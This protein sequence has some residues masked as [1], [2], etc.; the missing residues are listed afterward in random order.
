MIS[1]VIQLRKKEADAESWGSDF[2]PWE[3][4]VSDVEHVVVDLVAHSFE[5]IFR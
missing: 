3:M 2:V 5:Y 1:Y 4:N